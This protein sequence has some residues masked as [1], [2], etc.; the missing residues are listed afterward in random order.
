MLNVIFQ[1]FWDWLME[2][3]RN[4][5]MMTYEQDWLY[6]EFQ[7]LNAT[8]TDATMARRWLMEMGSAAKR[9]DITIQV[10]ILG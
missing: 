9:N 10:R 7:G 6:N 5:G 1:A 2:S 8:L 4:W 3:N